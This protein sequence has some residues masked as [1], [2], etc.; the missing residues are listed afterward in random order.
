MIRAA[1]VL[2]FA[3]MQWIVPLTP[4]LVGYGIPLDRAVNTGV[5]PPEQPTGATFAIWGVIFTLSVLYGL[6]QFSGRHREAA[7]YQAIGWSAAAAFA[8]SCAWMAVAQF[9][10]NGPALVAIIW[11]MFVFAARALF[12]LLAMRSVLDRF[13]R[14]ITLPLFAALSAW[15]AAAAVLNTLSYLKLVGVVTPALSPS[16]AAAGALVVVAVLSSALLARA[17]GYLAVAA[18]TLWALGGVAYANIAERPNREVAVLAVGLALIIVAQAIW[19]RRPGAR[20][21]W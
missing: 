12:R 14:W 7:A 19:L 6:R 15:L 17:R 1:L 11:L 5:P 21:E 13:D 8:G 9:V 20:R 18:T 16:L 3:A 10:G 4:R 2:L